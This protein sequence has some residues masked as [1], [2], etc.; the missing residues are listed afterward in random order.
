MRA[1]QTLRGLTAAALGVVRQNRAVKN[2][3]QGPN[4]IE[5]VAVAMRKLER[6]ELKPRVRALEAERAL[7]RV[8][9]L[10]QPPQRLPSLLVAFCCV[11]ARNTCQHPGRAG[12]RICMCVHTRIVV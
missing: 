5:D 12:M 8:Q 7:G 6:G 9:V 2:L 1:R 4:L 3:F 10:L 11:L